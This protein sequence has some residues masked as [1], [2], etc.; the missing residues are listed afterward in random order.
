M[1][2]E[3]RIRVGHI[4]LVRERIGHIYFPSSQGG[5]SGYKSKV[6]DKTGR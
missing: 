6:E 1:E 5:E 4:Y 3:T 2:K